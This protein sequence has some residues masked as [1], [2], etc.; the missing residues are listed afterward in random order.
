MTI[1][2]LADSTTAVNG[3]MVTFMHPSGKS[4]TCDLRAN[5]CS[6][7]DWGYCRHRDVAK[8]IVG[9]VKRKAA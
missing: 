9:M 8:V 6:C 3:M 5:V 7:G 4:V 1:K 2:E